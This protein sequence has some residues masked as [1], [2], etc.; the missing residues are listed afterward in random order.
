VSQTNF[1]VYVFAGFFPREYLAIHFRLLTRD[2]GSRSPEFSARSL[3]ARTRPV[4]LAQNISEMPSRAE[5]R[6]GPRC[7][8]GAY[9]RDSRLYAWLAI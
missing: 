8:R 7:Y 1:K 3:P 2:S 5:L 4:S 9:S 6:P